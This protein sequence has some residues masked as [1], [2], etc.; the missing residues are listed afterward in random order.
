MRLFAAHLAF[1]VAHLTFNAMN[2]VNAVNATERNTKLVKK[3]LVGSRLKIKVYNWYIV[4]CSSVY[5]SRA[6]VSCLV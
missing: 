4:V 2:A 3:R 5:Q 1:L 6:K